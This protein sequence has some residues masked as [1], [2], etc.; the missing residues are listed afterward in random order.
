MSATLAASAPAAAAP[1]PQTPRKRQAV[2]QAAGELFRAQGYGAVSMDAVAKAAGVS[3]ATLYAYFTGK[4][5]LFAEM[6]GTTCTALQAEAEHATHHHELPIREALVAIGT[7]WL[8]VMLSPRTVAIRRVVVAEGIRFPDLARAF[9]AAG[10]VRLKAWL[11]AWVQE[12]QRRG[13][14]RAEADP[15]L[16]GSQYTALLS[17][18]LFLRVTLGLEPAPPTEEAIAAT[19]TDAAETFLRAYGVG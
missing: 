19:A 5:A 13:R 14:L 4:D 10:P 16:A 6:V 8:R 11:T 3:K 18:E 2:L 15:A 1:P 17:S 9:Y 12:E 7:R